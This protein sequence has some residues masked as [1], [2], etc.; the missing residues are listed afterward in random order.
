[1]RLRRR[2][3]L[4]FLSVSAAGVAATGMGAQRAFAEECRDDRREVIERDVCVIGGGSSGTYSAVSLKDA[5]KSVVVVERKLRLGGHTETYVD[6]AT[7]I[8]TDYGVVVFNDTPVVEAYFARLGVT[9]FAIS[10]A[11]FGGPTVNFDLRTG[12]P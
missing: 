11:S 1:M 6:P 4:K 12:K 2:S 9:P 10:P 5:G 3:V 8:P 7:G